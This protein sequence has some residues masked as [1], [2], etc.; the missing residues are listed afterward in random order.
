MDNIKKHSI[1]QNIN[2]TYIPESK[3]K[4]TTISVLIFAPLD[5]KYASK[6]ALIPNLLAHSCKKY[7]SLLSISERLEELYGAHI[8][9]EVGNFGDNQIMSLS[10]QCINNSFIS[11]G[12]DNVLKSA[13]LLC[14]ILF[15]PNV[16]NNAFK[17]ENIEIEKRQLIEEI[18][19]EMSDKKLYAKKK[20]LEIM[21]KNE[22]FGINP[23]GNI[24]EAKKLNGKDVF[25][26]LQKLLQSSKIEII[27]TGSGAYQPVMKEFEKN[28]SK[29]ERKNIFPCENKIV[30]KASHVKEAEEFMD[31][32]QCKLV[33]GLRTEVAKPDPDVESVKVM[34]ALLGGTAQ[35]KLFV[36]VREKLSLCYYCSSRYNPQKGII[37]IESGIQKENLSKAK[38]EILKQIKDIQLGNFTN[39]ELAETKLFLS[40]SIEKIKDSPEK[41]SSWYGSQAFDEQ[42]Q[43]PEEMIEKINKVSR[44]KVIN[45]AKKIT[46]DTVYILS[47][48][49]N[50]Q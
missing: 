7:P 6:N 32:V 23:L 40:Q 29:I 26:A 1:G 39:K 22:P 47:G 10:I 11:D 45:V 35:S 2:F 8:F 5:E 37:F 12:S 28:F 44:E 4:T 3:F 49:E 34:N 50:K 16:S 9:P 15:N 33:I 13:S 43:S 18:E 46:T 31:V 42:K 14:D 30:K 17:E 19:S 21:C 38:E 24:E 41:L 20:C 27:M 36:N 48:K 25:E